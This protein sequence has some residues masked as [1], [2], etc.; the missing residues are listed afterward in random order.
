[1]LLKLYKKEDNRTLYWEAWDEDD[2]IV[3]HFGQ[4]GQL[5]E[6]TT[7][8]MAEFEPPTSA[9][10]NQA[11]EA[12]E[13]GFAEIEP[14]DLFELIVQYKIGPNS[15][16]SQVEFGYQVEEVLNDCLGW[17][18][19]GHCDG[20]D[21]A[22]GALNIYCYVVDPVL[23]GETIIDELRGHGHL[24]G[25]VIAYQDKNEEFVV[26]WP[27]NYAGVFDC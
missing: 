3:I 14:E 27:E 16:A 12:R 5:G 20:S 8:P 23:A 10:I 25:A 22:D 15:K 13:A 9:V 2:E 17:T 1:M 11:A 4:L 21:A 6:T 19:L 7:V 18:G 26:L 24:E